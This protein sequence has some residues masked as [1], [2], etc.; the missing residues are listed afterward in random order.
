MQIRTL[1]FLV[2]LVRGVL[3]AMAGLE[4]A[5]AAA[6][7]KPGKGKAAV[8]TSATKPTDLQSANAKLAASNP[9]SQ[10][11]VSKPGAKAGVID[12]EPALDLE[13]PSPKELSFVDE[14]GHAGM[15]GSKPAGAHVH[16]P[17]KPPGSSGKQESKGPSGIVLLLMYCIGF[18][19]LPLLVSLIPTAAF[20][21]TV[22]IMPECHNLH[23]CC[24]HE[25]SVLF[26]HHA[27]GT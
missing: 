1:G 12:E 7:H 27:A 6:M 22:A 16:I 25:M 5:L 17:V 19:K 9:S 11:D 8:Q 20:Q 14:E 21:L 15:E 13:A 3:E 23:P 26:T 18:L 10:T 24:I 4:G 2:S